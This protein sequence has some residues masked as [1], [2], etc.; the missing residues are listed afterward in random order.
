[1]S[2]GAAKTIASLPLPEVKRPS[3]LSETA[4]AVVATVPAGNSLAGVPLLHAGNGDGGAASAEG[5]KP[6]GGLTQRRAKGSAVTGAGSE[7]ALQRYAAQLKELIEQHKEYPLAARKARREGR[8]VLSF[9]LD[10]D[11]ALKR[12]AVVTSSSSRFLDN[13]SLAAV[14]AVGRF[15]VFPP[16]LRA[17][18]ETFGVTLSFRLGD[19]D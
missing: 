17:E 9:T 19:G 5:R 15:P 10:R 12:V 16:E 6:R 7:R 14:S 13:A 8:C 2:G 18:Q 3:G 11:G 1:M 4:P